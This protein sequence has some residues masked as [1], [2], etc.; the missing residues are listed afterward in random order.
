MKKII[1]ICLL[2]FLGH[3]AISQSNIDT[4]LFNPKL[5][6]QDK[7]GCKGYRVKVYKYIVD[8][9][10]SIFVGKSAKEIVKI[11][12]KPYKIIIA[13]DPYYYTYYYDITCTETGGEQG[14]FKFL[15]ENKKLIGIVI[16][17]SQ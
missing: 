5:W 14:E 3:C 15:F 7:D 11:F 9:Q 6:K 10:D 1:L 12:G 17:R 16:P 8:N 4:N 13:K 2:L